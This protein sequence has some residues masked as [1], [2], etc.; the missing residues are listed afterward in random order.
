MGFTEKRKDDRK[1]QRNSRKRAS[2]SSAL[3]QCRSMTPEEERRFG[4]AFKI[5]LAEM[6]RQQLNRPKA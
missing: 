3:V 4:A 1:Q 6:V 2:H 5:F